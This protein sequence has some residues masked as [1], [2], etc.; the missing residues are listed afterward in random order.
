MQAN[1]NSQPSEAMIT[2]T[3]FILALYPVVGF[4]SFAFVLFSDFIP[5]PFGGYADQRFFLTALCGF[6]VAA[7]LYSFVIKPPVSTRTAFTMML[8]TL[9]LC[10]ALLLL[11]ASLYAQPY[12]WAE[13]GMYAFFFLATVTS[14]SYLSWL[15]K[16]VACARHLVL[17]IAATCLIYGLASVNVYLFALSDG[18]TKL[19]DFIPWGFVNIRYWSHVA[20][21]CLPLLPLAVLVGPLK[22]FRSWRIAVL[23]GAGMWWWILFLTT[24][25]GSILGIVFGVT[26]AG[27]LL[28][29]GALPWLKVF[30]LYLAT[31]VV[32]WLILSILVPSF[33]AD[34]VQVR[35]IKADSSGRWPLWVEAWRMS[36]KNFPFGMGPQ[37]WLTHEPITEAYANGKKF[38]HPHNMYLMWAAEYGWLLIAALGVVVIQAIRNFWHRRAQ[39]FEAEDSDQLLLLAG[40]TA[41]VS[42]ALFHAGV[43][44]VF[45]APGSMLVGM[46]VLIAF[47]ALI[48][49]APVVPGSSTQSSS[50]SK[51][52][53]V[54][55]V[56][57]AT[58]IVLVWALWANQV[59]QY[60]KDMRAD[61]PHYYDHESEGTLPRFWFHGNFPREVSR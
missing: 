23:L 17:I 29:R 11:S 36:L 7:S 32:I 58:A 5:A 34:G 37:S 43:S 55:A 2:A 39:L 30:F 1:A 3:R 27:L 6:L 47:W 54:I 46:F 53:M 14:G 26:F 50:I 41:S 44:A 22:N 19:I 12:I 45:M 48:Q 24:G 8:P 25:R 38:G 61:E 60:Y 42:A 9:T 20:T 35:T 52:R 4:L 31:G 57:V 18:V 21:W 16:G 59:W 13:P 49:P 51:P 15:R 56:L 33:M 28:G 40:F 10:L